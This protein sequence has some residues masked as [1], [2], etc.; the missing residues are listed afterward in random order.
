MEE[1]CKHKRDIDFC[2]KC[3]YGKYGYNKDKSIDLVDELKNKHQ[4]LKD[5][6]GMLKQGNGCR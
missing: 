4:R 3:R 5:G 6:F 1:K 2:V